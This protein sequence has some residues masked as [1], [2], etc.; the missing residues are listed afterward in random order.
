MDVAGQIQTF[1]LE[2]GNFTE[3]EQSRL[4]LILLLHRF[5]P[6]GEWLAFPGFYK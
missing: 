3:I 6:G 4:T 2:Y 1:P 5:Y